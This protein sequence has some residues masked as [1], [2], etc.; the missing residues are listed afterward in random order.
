[1]LLQIHGTSSGRHIC[2]SK[3]LEV[4]PDPSR[5][6]IARQ[7][8][9]FHSAVSRVLPSL[10]HVKPGFADYTYTA[11]FQKVHNPL[12]KGKCSF[13]RTC[14]YSHRH[15]LMDMRTDVIAVPHAG[16]GFQFLRVSVGDQRILGVFK[17]RNGPKRK[18][19]NDGRTG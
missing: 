16:L 7:G 5:K 1:M 12:E 3:W 15:T 14:M 2:R 9:R 19:T 6:K 4:V 13:I 11:M 17:R 10:G 8:L 18:K